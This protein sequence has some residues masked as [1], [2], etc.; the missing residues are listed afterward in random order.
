[1]LGKQNRDIP[2]DL[3]RSRLSQIISLDH[4]LAQLAG[5]LDWAWIEHELRGYY[6]DEG[7]PSVPIRTMVGLLLLKQMYNHSDESVLERWVE[8]PYL[9]Y[10]TGETYFQHKP[11][12][13]PT[14]FVYF[15]K[16]VGEQGMEKVLSLT[17]KLHPGASQEKIVRIDTTV[18]EKNITFPT[19]SKLHQRII[20][21]LW[22]IAALED[23]RLRQSY[24][25]VLK[26]LRLDMHN[27]HHPRNR[28]KSNKARRKIKTICG[29][30]LRDVRRKLNEEQLDWYAP[31]LALYERV[32]DQKK[33]DKNKVYSLHEPEV[34]CI[35]KGKAHKKY[36]F[37]NKVAVTRAAR[38][39]VI[40]GMKSFIEN[41]FDGHALEPALQQAENIC[42][43]IGGKRAEIAVVDRGCRGR[44]TIDGTQILIPGKA[45]KD[46]TAYEKRKLRKLFRARA[47]IEPVIGHLKYDHR[48]LRNYLKGTLGDAVNALLAGAAFN[49]KKRLNQIK[50]ALKIY[51]LTML[52]A[53][54][55]HDNRLAHQITLR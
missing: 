55:I 28:K 25:F 26:R 34:R 9:Q 46:Q 18:Q 38:S 36:E 39:G 6:S 10:F 33:N 13:D 22:H 35:A 43:A 2:Q 19:D 14:D 15:R 8:N 47:G 54:L 37:G 27:G 50:Q 24:K 41:V 49:L 17:I 45:P 31:Y 12:F 23:I 3:F 5:E 1:M 44:K 32:L 11:P 53:F 21:Y 7:R 29:R 30:L 42:M 4:E 52:E 51:F 16:R 48:M 20:D 40:L